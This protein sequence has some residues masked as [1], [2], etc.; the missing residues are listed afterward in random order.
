MALQQDSTKSFGST[1]YFQ[2]KDDERKAVNSIR[3]EERQKRIATQLLRRNMKKAMRRGEDGSNYIQSAK[4]AGLDVFTRTGLGEEASQ[5]MDRARFT[6][7]ENFNAAAQAKAQLETGLGNKQNQAAGAIPPQAQSQANAG[8]T[9]AMAN[10]LPNKS[11]KPTAPDWAKDV[12]DDKTFP[13]GFFE[14]EKNLQKIQGKSRAEVYDMLRKAEAARFMSGAK[15]KTT[16][17][18]PLTEQQVLRE[19]LNA[20]YAN[21]DKFNQQQVEERNKLMEFVASN[22]AFADQSEMNV[23][24]F[25]NIVKGVQSVANQSMDRAIGAIDKSKEQ[26]AQA[27]ATTEEKLKSDLAAVEFMRKTERD[28]RNNPKLAREKQLDDF[29]TAIDR[30]KIMD[31]D[32]KSLNLDERQLLPPEGPSVRSRIEALSPNLKQLITGVQRATDAIAYAQNLT[33]KTFNY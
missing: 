7:N 13:K 6:A 22:K 5:A 27:N 19:K 24:N 15:A 4:L 9:P 17:Q 20:M 14:N 12:A 31:I 30:S 23:N 3:Q 28:K 29:N 10:A 1:S 26:A 25:A 16:A 21:P 32:R 2:N 33:I 18:E 8:Q 11:A